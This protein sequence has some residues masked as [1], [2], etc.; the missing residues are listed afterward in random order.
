MRIMREYILPEN[1]Y[2]YSTYDIYMFST[3]NNDPLLRADVKSNCHF[4][5]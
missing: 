3:Y 2:V 4:H 5:S 1:V